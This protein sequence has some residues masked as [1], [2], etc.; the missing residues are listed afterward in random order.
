M[1]SEPVI[2][3]LKPYLVSVKAGKKYLW[4]ACGRSAR[5]PFCDASH[6]GTG[7]E[8]VRFRA[9]RDEDLLFCGCKHTGG[10]PLCDG[11]H[12]NLVEKYEEAE[13]G[14]GDEAEAVAR[15]PGG[16]KTALDGGCFVV[17]PGEGAFEA[18]G[19]AEIRNV[20]GSSDGAEYLSHFH[21]RF[22]AGDPPILSFGERDV[23]LFILAGSGEIEISGRRFRVAPRMGVHIRKGEA[24]RLAPAGDVRVEALLSVCP[25]AEKPERLAEMPT[26]F[27]EEFTTRTA[28]ID[29][30]QRSKMA[31][32]FYQ[33]LIGEETG[34]D[35]VTQFVGE[36]PKSRAAYHHH[37]YEELIYVLTGSGAMWT[38]GHKTPVAPGDLIFLPRRQMH[39][40]E[41]ESDDGMQLVG[42]FYPAGSPAI[43]Y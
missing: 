24:F 1:A 36:I 16:G 22:G 6:V 38:G 41:C 37:L 10:P 23:V 31:D 2:A 11:T 27:D 34:S 33:V 21:A 18:C 9:E 13:P 30:A 7:I 28:M 26:A 29:E 43:N 5:Q 3:R 12:N 17:A 8:P 32:R 15:A 19:S 14:D 20:V 25:Q 40:L 39:S 42:L 35:E 4:C